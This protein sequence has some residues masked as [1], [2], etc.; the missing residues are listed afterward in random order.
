MLRSRYGKAFRAF[1]L[2]FGL[3]AA[4]TS[5]AA[6]AIQFRIR[7]ANGWQQYG[8]LPLAAPHGRG[9]SVLV[10]A[11]HSD[12]E[13]L[14]CGGM[15]A[16]AAQK[17]AKVRVVLLTNG[18]GFRIA[19]GT[20]YRTIKVTPEMCIDFAYRRQ[21][22]TLKALSVLGVRKDQV[23]FLGYPDRGIAHLWGKHWGDDSLYVSHAT[24]TDRSPYTNS[25]TPNAPHCGESLMADIQRVIEEADPTDIYIPHPWDDHSDH[26]A[27]YC[28]VTAAI[29]QIR[30]EGGK[31]SD[32]VRVH[33]YLVHRGDWPTPKG[34][35]PREA[36]SPP[37][38]LASGDTDWYSLP[39]PAD[40]VRAKRSA[41]MTY[42]TQT[43][44]ERGFLMS[45]ARE[46]E[47]FGSLPPRRVALVPRNSISVD[48]D[49][50]DWWGI[51]PAVVNPTGDNIVA[52][53]NKGGDVRAI[54]LSSDDSFLYIRLDFVRNLSKRIIYRVNLRGLNDA[55]SN[56]R[57]T[58]TISPPSRANPP[59]TTWG[60]KRNIMEIALPRSEF[61]F[62]NDVFVQVSTR[63]MKL[64][65]DNTGWH[66]LEFARRIQGRHRPQDGDEL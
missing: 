10:F 28:F 25:Y 36:L 33:T 64:K 19:V 26:Y 38:A 4:V 6:L 53:I 2:A 44:I 60:Y 35:Y 50:E 49:P 21:Q 62:D 34:D 52:G 8:R 32:R 42:K 17:G 30:F 63:V 9:D 7:V 18:D 3:L 40:I 58:I 39:L 45:F 11:P 27:T 20:A 1:G 65:V 46:N 24:G 29:E 54:Y 12:D 66:R 22:E 41:I 48:G 61:V 55:R 13:T 23:A 31:L 14:G 5:V 51:P 56:D 57:H 47:L 43:A 59:G 37:S 16:L 15:L